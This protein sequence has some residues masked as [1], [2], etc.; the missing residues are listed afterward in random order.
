MSFSILDITETKAL[1]VTITGVVM[2]TSIVVQRHGYC[3][4][5]IIAISL[6][7]FTTR[8]NSPKNLCLSYEDGNVWETPTSC[9]G[10]IQATIENNGI[11]VAASM[12]TS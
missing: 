9:N 12:L 7:H 10:M 5:M 4:I 6:H 1:N 8:Q 3:H 2:Q 11:A